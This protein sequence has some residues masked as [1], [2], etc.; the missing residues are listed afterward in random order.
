MENSQ[1][2]DQTARQLG[3][4]WIRALLEKDYQ[5]LAEICQPDIH[6]RLMTPRRVDSFENVSDL[7][8]KVEYWFRECS[9]LQEEQSRV[10]MVGEKLAIFYRLSFQKNGE[11]YLAEQQVYCSYQEGLIDT[12]SLLCS[13]F[14]PVQARVD[15]PIP[16]KEV[17]TANRMSSASQLPIQADA[18]LSFDSHS[19][20]GSIC[21]LLTP[22]IKRKLGEMSSGQV[23]EINVDDP[24]AK[25]DIEAWCRLS[26]N[27][28]LNSDLNA[29]STNHF[30]VVKK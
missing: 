16:Q 3:E 22:S 24:S 29:G 1:V 8:Q 17:S 21:A 9:S 5:R 28:L 6:S 15:R 27:A 7:A 14:Q 26:G 10:A 2:I 18:F 11:A 30:Y 19:E 20:Q 23:L 25:E 4:S 12:L 13:G